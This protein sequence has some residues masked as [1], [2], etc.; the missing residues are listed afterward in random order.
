MDIKNAN[1][2]DFLA[3]VTG[4]Q[5][6]KWG[7]EVRVECLDDPIDRQPYTLVFKNCREVQWQVYKSNY[8]QDTEAD[9]IGVLLGKDMYQERAIVT[10]DIFEV[11]VL[12]GSFEVQKVM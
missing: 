9:L 6:L 11:S 7:T 10:T 8:L 4:V 5:I 1:P 2:Q 12:Y 3:I